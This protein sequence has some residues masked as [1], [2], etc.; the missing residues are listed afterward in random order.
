MYIIG[1]VALGLIAIAIY[2]FILR[3]LTPLLLLKL[4][5][6][7]KAI[8]MFNPI[9]GVIGLLMNSIKKNHDAMET[10]YSA[11]RRNPNA[12]V[13]LS[14]LIY[15]PCIVLTGSEYIRDSFLE[16]HNF[17]K[18]N[19]FQIKSYMQKGLVFSE[20][21]RWKRQ[22]NFL[23]SAFTFEKL[24]SRIPMMNL[25][26]ED[27]VQKD[28][29][30][31]LNEFISRMTGEIV[32]KSF[33][34]DLAEGFQLEGKDAQL[35]LIDLTGSMSQI[36]FEN[37][38]IFIKSLIFKER[39]WDIFPSQKEKDIVRRVDNVKMKVKE[40]ILKRIEQL[41]QNPIQDKNK[42]VFLDLYVTEYLQ[43]QSQQKEQLIDIEEII[44]Q[45]TTLFFVG[46]DTTATAIGTC[47]YY[48]A[49]YPEI[50]SE[51]LEEVQ[52]VIGQ[53]E[54]KEEH[55]NKLVKINALI[56]E[57]LRFKNPSYSTIFRVVKND[58]Q[59]QE[60]KLKKGWALIQMQNASHTQEKY[61]DG[62]TEF[63]YKRWLNKQKQVKNDN[64]YI[65]IP[66]GAGPRNCIGQHMAMMESKIIIALLVRKYKILLNPEVQQQIRFGIKFLYILEPDNCLLFEK[67]I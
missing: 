43:Q 2:F 45:F 54:I 10:I 46:T 16:H 9:N 39:M 8:L 3:P 34:G 49:K 13:I 27:I 61:F 40:M 7:D 63:N 59:L 28:S 23:G 21:D 50:Q 56:Q 14:N 47:L 25:V 26:V 1:F 38:F 60:I 32:I 64:G 11:L 18:M 12:K 44:H 19:P 22:R 53:N 20:G 6:G 48:L 17:E 15:K 55:L 41:R 65:Y 66:F 4:K 58:T 57:V 31:N 29:K 24:K 33:F 30:K 36:Q 52:E 67:R 35:A 42:M 62:A 37:P 51:I 5:L